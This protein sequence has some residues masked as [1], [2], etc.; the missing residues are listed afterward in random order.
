MRHLEEGRGVRSRPP[1][2]ET[3]RGAPKAHGAPS[4]RQ[5]RS[6]MATR[7]ASHLYLLT[8]TVTRANEERHGQADLRGECVP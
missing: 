3:M 5:R 1:L 8:G 4:R 2:A 7:E 6:G